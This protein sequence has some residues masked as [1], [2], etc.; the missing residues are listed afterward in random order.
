MRSFIK[1]HD[2]MKA[3]TIALQ[4]YDFYGD[5]AAMTTFVK[6]L[7]KNKQYDEAYSVVQRHGEKIQEYV[8]R[9]LKNKAKPKN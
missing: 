2:W 5:K 8:V 1:R 6:V 3:E 4:R 7:I 9:Q